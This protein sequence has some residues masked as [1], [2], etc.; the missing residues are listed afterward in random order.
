M[1]IH[2]LNAAYRVKRSRKD[3]DMDMTNVKIVGEQ[4]KK[5]EQAFMRTE[6]QLINFY[7]S[8]ATDKTLKVLTKVAAEGAKC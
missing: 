4:G 6:K 5:G 3:T 1:T 2:S 7:K 8:A